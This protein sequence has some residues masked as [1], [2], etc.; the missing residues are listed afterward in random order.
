MDHVE[1]DFAQW[2]KTPPPELHGDAIWRLPAYRLSRYLALAVRDDI[3]IVRRRS[4]SM[5]DQL[6][7]SVDSIGIN[8]AEGYS[9]MHGRER[10]RFY[11]YAMG[12]LLAEGRLIGSRQAPHSDNQDSDGRYSAGTCWLF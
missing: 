12:S 11:E 1:L 7:R 9:R 8:I 2:E 3:N 10:A 5:A 6:E 4:P